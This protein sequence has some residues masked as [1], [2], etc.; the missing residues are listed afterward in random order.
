M[1][2]QRI[3][4]RD[5]SLQ[6]VLPM[7]V[8]NSKSSYYQGTLYSAEAGQILEKGTGTTGMSSTTALNII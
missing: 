1:L 8:D 6:P 7:Y 3:A 2:R 5:I 4:V